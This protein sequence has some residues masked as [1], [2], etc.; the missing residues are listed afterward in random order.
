MLCVV[1]VGVWVGF[2][3]LSA[4]VIKR[5]NALV[6]REQELARRQQAEKE[7]AV[8]RGL[9]ADRLGSALSLGLKG[10]CAA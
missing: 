2:A 7:A 5:Q 9:R 4:A 1:C 6:A 10:Q 3:R 8:E